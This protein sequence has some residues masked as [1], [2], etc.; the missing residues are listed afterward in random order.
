ME[1]VQWRCISTFGQRGG[2]HERRQ[3]ISLAPLQE[4]N[5]FQC[6]PPRALYLIFCPSLDIRQR[7]ELFSQVPPPEV[8]EADTELN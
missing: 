2:A 3:V 4:S 5:S 7:P 8:L 1:L 6:R